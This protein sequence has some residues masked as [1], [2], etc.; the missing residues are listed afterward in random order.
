MDEQAFITKSQNLYFVTLAALILG[1]IFDYL[2]FKKYIG[3]SVVIFTVMII[4]AILL[5]S[6]YYKY[7]IRQI[8]WLI[9]LGIFFSTMVAVR[10]NLFLTFLNIL[11][12]VGLLLLVA[13]VLIKD[14]IRDF[15]IKD[16]ISTVFLTP[17]LMV[18]RCFNV[19]STI[20]NPAK[21]SSIGKWKLV[22]KGVLMA[23]PFLVFFSLLFASADLAFKNFI[24]SIFSFHISDNLV[25]HIII[26]ISV[27]LASLGLL[28][29][30]FNPKQ[31]I[32][33]TIG[34]LKEN[35]IAMRNIET[36]V[37]LW[38]IVG[39]FFVFIVFQ[40]AY[41]FGGGINVGGDGFTYAEYA[42]R[43]FWEL[44]IVSFV[45]L[46][47]LLLMDFYSRRSERRLSWFTVPSLVM[48]AEIFII[49]VSALK[50]IMLYQSAYGWTSLRLYVAGFIIF[51][52][53]IF[54][55]FAIKLWKE[56]RS[57]FFAFGVLIS[58]ISFLIGFNI[59]NPDSFIAQQNIQRFNETGKIDLNYLSTMSSD[60][61]LDILSVYDRVSDDDQKY[62]QE[63]L[64]SKKNQLE[65]ETKH[66]QSYNYSR[67]RALHY[68]NIFLLDKSF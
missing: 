13:R 62:L 46:L 11:A 45:T 53:G 8:I 10:S 6:L 48:I 56:K 68:L 15:S 30:I 40:I 2:F 5:F 16:Y 60:A 66:W 36:K 28:A 65:E 49:I 24:D 44:L 27:S 64:S 47:V 18:E 63:Q 4:T 58:M 34:S 19:F 57:N 54:I 41:L 22:L 31:K 43:G 3:V 33:K 17:L 52:A 59:L 67:M 9:G 51:L 42:R 7:L 61:T 26:I 23:M 37:F 35:I 50:R 32:G 55:I 1:V 25:A 14:K 12:T 21:S 29:Y 39:L 20:I 38:L